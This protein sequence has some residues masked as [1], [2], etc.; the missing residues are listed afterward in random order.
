MI[1]LIFIPFTRT[2]GPEYSTENIIFILFFWRKPE[3][4]ESQPGGLVFART[5]FLWFWKVFTAFAVDKNAFIYEVIIKQLNTF[6][7]LR[8]SPS[9]F[10]LFVLW[11][12]WGDDVACEWPRVEHWIVFLLKC[13][14]F[15]W[16]PPRFL[17]TFP[18]IS[19]CKCQ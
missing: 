16:F 7:S 9:G 15:F 12:L 17:Y 4:K 5:E 10:C 6:M 1:Y 3:K 19:V 14:V 11:Y 2:L 8:L 18:V 13:N